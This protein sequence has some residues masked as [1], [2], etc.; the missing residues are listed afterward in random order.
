MSRCLSHAEIEQLSDL[1]QNSDEHAVLR[2]HLNTCETCQAAVQQN[3]LDQQ[4][5]GQLRQAARIGVRTERA[6]RHA[7]YRK[8]AI[9][10]Y[11]IQNE[12]HRG[13]QGVVFRAT[14]L[15]TH[16]DVAIKFVLQGAFASEQQQLR[17]EREVDVAS[18]LRHPNIVT[19]YDSGMT[20][21][22]QFF[23]MELIEGRPLNEFAT[24]QLANEKELD[25]FVKG[26][27]SMVEEKDYAALV[28][29][30]GVRRNAPWF[31]HLSDRF[32]DYSRR[33][34]PREAGLFDLNRYQ[35]R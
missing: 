11:E 20:D 34:F 15:S 5:M 29:R 12:I 7:D 32:H 27:A 2:D 18:R 30:Y 16:R 10:G 24:I 22:Q 4:L 8:R 25:S 17:F 28:A 14:Q 19:V 1:R 9:P 13:G 33:H 6:E 23:V 35:N 26:I 21:G 3:R 31:W